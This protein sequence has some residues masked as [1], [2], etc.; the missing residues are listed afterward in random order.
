MIVK[1][2]TDSEDDECITERGA[3][4]YLQD[5]YPIVG[6]PNVL[7]SATDEECEVYAIILQCLGPTLDD[8]L[9]MLPEKKFNEKMVLSVAIQMVSLSLIFPLIVCPK[10]NYDLRCNTFFACWQL[11]RYKEIHAGGVIHNGIK[12]ANICLPPVPNPQDDVKPNYD[13]STL[14]TIDFGL[15]SFLSGEEILPKDHRARIIGNRCFLSTFAHHGISMSF[16]FYPG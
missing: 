3:Y 9:Q 10:I 13:R 6:I 14:Y 11:D 8:V 1:A 4:D 5:P 7:E 12:P 15:S 16:V 2:W